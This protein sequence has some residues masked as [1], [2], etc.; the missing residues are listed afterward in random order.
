ML[1]LLTM[2]PQITL[3][4]AKA[5]ESTARL[6]TVQAAARELHKGHSAILYLI[7]HL[8]SQLGLSL[9]D[10]KNYRNQLSR[11]GQ[12]ILRH[13][14][15][16]LQKHDELISASLQLKRGFEPL[17]TLVYDGVVDFNQIASALLKIKKEELPTDIKI[18]TGFLDEVETIFK[19]H[20]A[21]LMLTIL[22]MR[23]H[24]ME[25]TPLPAIDMLLVAHP[26]HPLIANS[27]HKAPRQKWRLQDVAEHHLVHVREGR[28]SAQLGFETDGIQFRS[29]IMVNDFPTKREAILR[30][31]GI[32]WLPRY[33][34]ERQLKNGSLKM[35][36]TQFKNNH[37]LEP[38]IYHPPLER[39]GPA[40]QKLLLALIHQ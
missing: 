32:G 34:I 24:R 14:Q 2:I 1:V 18:F 20:Q 35:I 7:R 10:R 31:L 11:Q 22:P 29:T 12:M 15:E 5:F 13:C 28:K 33:L 39:A 9:F 36:K 6:G 27:S 17:I 19:D 30:N 23:N 37:R 25:S 8:E 26:D 38:R 4:Q 40:V 3:D 21:D 16:L